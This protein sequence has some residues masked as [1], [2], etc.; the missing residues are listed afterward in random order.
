[1]STYSLR[2]DVGSGFPGK[3]KLGSVV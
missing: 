2:E 3:G 1:M